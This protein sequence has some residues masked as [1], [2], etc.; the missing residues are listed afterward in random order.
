MEIRLGSHVD[1]DQVACHLDVAPDGR[2]VVERPVELGQEV[3]AL[4]IVTLAL[5]PDL[6]HHRFDPVHGATL[7]HLAGGGGE[8]GPGGADEGLRAVQPIE[9]RHQAR[10]VRRRG[11]LDA[12]PGTEAEAMPETPG[13]GEDLEV[14]VS[15]E[16]VDLDRHRLL[17]A[18]QI[19]LRLLTTEQVVGRVPAPGE[20]LV[21][22]LP[23]DELVGGQSEAR[24]VLGE[25]VQRTDALRR[26]NAQQPVAPDID[27]EGVTPTP[28]AA[29]GSGRWGPSTTTTS[30]GP[31]PRA[32][33]HPGASVGPREEAGQA[34]AGA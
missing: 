7:E 32:R 3:V 31:G 5:R 4:D 13:L 12:G 16:G 23:A 11:R 34:R 8:E 30:P 27:D 18:A 29:S 9:Q 17:E 19:A 25:P 20:E 2:E 10:H 6:G 21:G 14:P 24:L 22:Y 28:P 33:E 15:A 1:E 26:E